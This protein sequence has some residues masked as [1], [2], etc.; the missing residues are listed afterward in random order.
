MKPRDILGIVVRSTA[1]FFFMN[2][3]QSCFARL[4]EAAFNGSFA[5]HTKAYL[6]S[7]PLVCISVSAVLFCIARPLERLAYPAT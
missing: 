1:F 2:A 4:I 3:L 7:Q 5:E 6:W